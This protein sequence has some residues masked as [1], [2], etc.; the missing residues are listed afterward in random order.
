MGL[1]HVWEAGKKLAGWQK[2][3]PQARFFLTAELF[4]NIL[5]TKVPSDY[6]DDVAGGAGLDWFGKGGCLDWLTAGGLVMCAAIPGGAPDV[7]QG[8]KDFSY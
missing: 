8:T 6:D 7:W 4:C 3:G 1:A 2:L 5:G